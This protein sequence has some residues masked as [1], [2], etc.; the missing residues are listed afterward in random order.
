MDADVELL[1]LAYDSII[2]GGKVQVTAPEML[3]I[4]GTSK[5][6]SKLVAKLGGG[7]KQTP[8]PH[9]VKMVTLGY[10]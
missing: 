5:P 10:S 1:K 8:G 4:G 6:V 9:S 2:G 7:T 3:G